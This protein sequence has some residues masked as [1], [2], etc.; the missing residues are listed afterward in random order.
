MDNGGDS[1]LVKQ[2][3]IASPSKTRQN[4]RREKA[5]MQ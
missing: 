1:V 5:T 4:K 2:G 3:C